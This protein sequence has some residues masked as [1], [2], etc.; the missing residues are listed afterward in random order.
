M[1]VSRVNTP[2]QL[3][4]RPLL[5]DLVGVSAVSSR[6]FPAVDPQ[7]LGTGNEG[8]G[9]I[10]L[11]GQLAVSHKQFQLLVFD[12]GLLYLV[13]R[14][15]VYIWI[16]KD[17]LKAGFGFWRVLFGSGCF[18]SIALVALKKS[19]ARSE[20]VLGLGNWSCLSATATLLPRRSPKV[21]FRRHTRSRGS[22][23][24]H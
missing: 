4:A 24:K 3:A 9:V 11:A 10:G 7:R 1:D 18:V 20:L 2:S 17:V 19:I 23:V 5:A 16:H 12:I 22:W 14:K 8:V 15:Y 21:G 6:Q 13:V